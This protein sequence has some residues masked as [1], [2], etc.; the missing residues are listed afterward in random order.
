[1]ATAEVLKAASNNLNERFSYHHPRFDSTPAIHDPGPHTIEY[2]TDQACQPKVQVIDPKSLCD[3]EIDYG[4]LKRQLKHKDRP[5]SLRLKNLGKLDNT[6]PV[7]TCPIHMSELPNQLINSVLV[8]PNKTPLLDFKRYFT[9][10]KLITT[11]LPKL[12]DK[13]EDYRA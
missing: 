11:R 9:R 2:L 1:M 6:P 3:R 7:I 4:H 5:P 12:N 10:R 13:P 8:M